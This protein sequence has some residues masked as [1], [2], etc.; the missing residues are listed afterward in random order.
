MIES[1]YEESETF[2]CAPSLPVT[3]NRRVWWDLCSSSSPRLP[4]RFKEKAPNRPCYVR[5]RRRWIRNQL[6]E[7]SSPA[8]PN[9]ACFSWPAHVL[10]GEGLRGNRLSFKERDRRLRWGLKGSRD[11]SDSDSDSL[12]APLSNVCSLL[13]NHGRHIPIHGCLDTSGLTIRC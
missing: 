1:E 9:V 13:P 3:L 11:R 5:R 7:Q 4:P 6:P 10:N 2:T 8:A 12:Q